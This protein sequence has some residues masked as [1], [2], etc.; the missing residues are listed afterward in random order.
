MR[1]YA[2]FGLAVLAIATLGLATRACA[3]PGGLDKN[4]CHLDKATGATHCHHEPK[5]ATCALEHAPKAGDEGVFYGPLIRVKDGDTV[6]V[7]IQGVVMDFRLAEIDAPESA[8][9]YGKKSRD[10]L[11]SLVKDRQ[12]VL[13]PTDTDRYGRTVAFLW[14]GEKCINEAM[15]RQGAAWFYSKYS[16]DDYLYGVENEARDSKRGLWALPLKDRIEPWVF[17][18]EHR[19]K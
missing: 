9:P 2:G 15:V 8:Q 3:H 11:L 16:T 4:G 7:K 18:D 17:R 13:V 10:E 19:R 1:S 14:V 6:D 5:I 12:V